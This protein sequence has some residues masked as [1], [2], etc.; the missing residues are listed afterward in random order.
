MSA[1]LTKHVTEQTQVRVNALFYPVGSDTTP[2]DPTNTKLYV[3]PPGDPVP[4][5]YIYGQPGSPII[6][7]VAGTYHAFLF[8]DRPGDWWVTWQ[9]QGS[10]GPIAVGEMLIKARNAVNV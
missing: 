8:I 6:R 7:G 2:F 3:R 9:G 5:T 1:V 4:I 10:T